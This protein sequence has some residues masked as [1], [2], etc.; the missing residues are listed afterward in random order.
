MAV[1]SGPPAGCE[2]LFTDHSVFSFVSEESLFLRIDNPSIIKRQPAIKIRV[3]MIS[4][5]FLT[6]LFSVK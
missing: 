1:F 4:S 5:I 3:E 2:N 6:F